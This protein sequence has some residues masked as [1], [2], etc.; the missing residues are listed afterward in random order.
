M[1]PERTDAADCTA[2]SA[3]QHAYFWEPGLPAPLFAAAR[4]DDTQHLFGIS[5]NG[6]LIGTNDGGAAVPYRWSR[7]E[8][9]ASL[10]IPYMP[11]IAPDKRW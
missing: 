5:S 2:Q 1:S 7:S 4:R 10:G 11:H 6:I 3:A 9:Y 8:G